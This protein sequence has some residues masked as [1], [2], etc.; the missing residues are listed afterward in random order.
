MAEKMGMTPEEYQAYSRGATSPA[1][2][3]VNEMNGNESDSDKQIS[4]E[5]VEDEDSSQPVERML[6]RELFWK[7]LGKNFT[8]QERTIMRLYYYEDRSMKDI[9]DIVGLSESRVSQMHTI[10]LKRLRNKADRNPE[11]FSDIF[12]FTEKFKEAAPAI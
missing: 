8:P 3:S 9:S 10:I 12:G 5:H 4:I 7:L 2:H 6:R 1:I 11:Y